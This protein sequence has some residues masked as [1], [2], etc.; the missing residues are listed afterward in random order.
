MSNVGN[1][2]IRIV[3]YLYQNPGNICIKIRIL[4]IF[5]LSNGSCP[6]DPSPPRASPSHWRKCQRPLC[7]A[8]CSAPNCAPNKHCYAR[9]ASNT[10]LAQTAWLHITPVPHTF[11]TLVSVQRSFRA[12]LH[13]ELQ[14]SIIFF[15][16][17]HHTTQIDFGQDWCSLLTSFRPNQPTVL[18]PSH[19]FSL[20]AIANFGFSLGQ[21]TNSGFSLDQTDSHGF[22]QGSIVNHGFHQIHSVPR[23]ILWE[24]K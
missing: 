8:M 19:G 1:I 18:L 14:S 10:A 24:T 2:S 6:P 7:A 21:S 12:A 3:S 13:V 22:S 5:V 16:E 17:Q 23:Q 15:A 9:S 11:C 20:P 4:V